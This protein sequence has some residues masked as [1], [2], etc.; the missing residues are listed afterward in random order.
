MKKSVGSK[1]I[2]MALVLVLSLTFVPIL[3]TKAEA[4][5][6]LPSILPK[7]VNYE[8]GTGQ[9]VLTQNTSIYVAGNTNEETEEIYKIG[10][11][12]ADKLNASTGFNISVIKSNDPRS[13]SIYLTTI[14]GTSDKGN[15][16]YDLCTTA[17][18]VTLTAY[19][20]EGVFRG[21]QTL[22]QLLPAEV[23]KNTVIP[24]VQWVIP[25]SNISDK[26]SYDYRGLMLDVTRHFFTVDQVERQIDLASQYKINKLH[27]H[28]SDDQG[29]RIEIKS[30][31]DLIT[32]GSTTCVGGGPGGYYTQDQFK[33]IVNYAAERYI[34]VIPEI[35]MPGHTNAA[36]ASIPELNPD[37]KRKEVY[38]GINVGFSSLMC[39]SEVTYSFVDDVIRELAAIS[40]SPYIHIGGDEASSTS[41][42]DY[43]YFMGRVTDIARKYGKKTVG[44][45]PYDRPAGVG[46]DSILQNWHCSGTA[47]QNAMQK[48]MKMILSPANAYIDQKYYADS[49][50]GLSWRGYVNTNRA[51]SWDPADIVPAQ[52]IYGTEST[53]WTET[54]VT[55]DNMDYLLYPRLIANA[56]V[57]WTPKSS[58]NWDDFK[59]RLVDHAP[60]MQ[61]KG[62][63][64]FED[65]IVWE[66]PKVQVNSEWKMDE[67]AGTTVG[68]TS[69]YKNGTLVNGT[70]EAGKFGSAVKFNGTSAYI[71]L[72][73]TEIAGD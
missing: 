56:E 73:G 68:D 12:L 71:N 72:G 65:P 52:Y 1:M 24:G 27:L 2:S 39:R 35:D 53:L 40:P 42:Q 51:Y 25:C 18:K 9:F 23:E 15:E 63:K 58:R 41:A 49:P 3:P 31:P 44:W 70:W 66:A 48:G 10:K 6:N 67:G 4:V 46:A 11:M 57:G 14:G 32:Y 16:G 59:A 20:P 19:K 60:R 45:D 22:R 61:N 21:I 34:E 54:V 30:R 36:L 64:Y 50:I 29:W 69:G 47:G 17:D 55:Q 26:P 33:E 38:T 28:L 8:A 62:I 13:G 43:D 37:G 5:L 7:P